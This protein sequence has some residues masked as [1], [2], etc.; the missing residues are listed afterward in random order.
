M[1]TK[2]NVD[3]KALIGNQLQQILASRDEK[4]FEGKISAIDNSL[5]FETQCLR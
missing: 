1:A 5:S 2:L 3:L 4:A